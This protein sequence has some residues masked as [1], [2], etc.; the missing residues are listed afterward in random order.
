MEIYMNDL[1]PLSKIVFTPSE[2]E[3]TC[4]LY[5]RTWQKISEFKNKLTHLN[6][7]SFDTWMNAFASKKY[8]FY[9][10]IGNIFLKLDIIGNYKVIIYGAKF[11]HLHGVET[12]ILYQDYHAGPCQIKISD[13]KEFESLFFKIIEKVEDPVQIISAVWMTDSPPSS[14]NKLAIVICTYKRDEYI[15]NNINKFINY[16]KINSDISQRINIFIIDNGKTLSRSLCD[17]N[18][19]I[20]PN[21]NAGGAGGFTRGMIEVVENFPGINRILLMDDDV[22]IIPEVFEKTLNLCDYLK[23]EYKKSFVSGAMLDKKNKTVFVEQLG[24]I[25]GFINRPPLPQLDL[26]NFA[27]VCLVNVPETD[28]MFDENNKLHDAWWYH[29]FH[30]DTLKNNGLPLPFFIRGDDVEW[31]KRNFG[32]HFISMNGICIWHDPFAW[33]VSDI[34]SC[35]FTIRNFFFINMLY[36]KNYF[37]KFKKDLW[38]YFKPLV[39][40]WN[41]NGIEIFF[42]ALNDIL[43]AGESLQKN[44]ETLLIKLKLLYSKRKIIN[45]SY[46]DV[47]SAQLTPPSASK[48]K[49]WLYRFSFWN[50]FL[51]DK[52]CKQIDCWGSET[53]PVEYFM[54]NNQVNIINP[55]TKNGEI[56]KLNRRLSL[57]YIFQF[58]LFLRK[59]DSEYYK[60]LN[61]LEK[62]VSRFRSI[63]FWK[64]YLK[65][66]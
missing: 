31:G 39:K 61:N 52:L 28:F 18:I 58:F 35:Y 20:L 60:I 15:I 26:N 32:N 51:P 53:P 23:D 4:N 21:I 41:Y 37:K 46:I 25:S 2:E 40:T 1:Y 48:K 24:C 14:K 43:K 44:P 54:L 27:N 33:R 57:K 12:K 63:E 55:L 50:I 66:N 49:R 8:F 65:I 7:F 29:C 34:V 11:S 47:N 13:A 3:S 30:V 36:D 6:V 10:N 16:T 64:E 56:R 42:E 19:R 38:E 9:C 62:D 5:V 59:L 45:Y 17:K 22:E